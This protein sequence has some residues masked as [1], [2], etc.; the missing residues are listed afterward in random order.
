MDEEEDDE[1]EEEE[2]VAEAEAEEEDMTL[3]MRGVL[4][5]EGVADEAIEDR[6]TSWWGGGE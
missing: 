6:G 5:R 3:E 4:E 2:D 1:D